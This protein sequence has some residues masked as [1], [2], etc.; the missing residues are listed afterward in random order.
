MSLRRKL[1]FAIPLALLVAVG[2][3]K[4]D[5]INYFPPHPAQV[6]VINLMIEPASLD[7]QIGGS[8]AFSAVPFQAL[9]GYQS[10][11]NKTTSF[12]IAVTGSTTPLLSFNYPLAG[13][14]PYTLVLMGS[15]SNPSATLLAEVANAPTNGNIQLSVFNAAINNPS[16]DI[17]VTAP[18]ADITQL[19]PSYFNVSYN[20]VSLNLAY[21]PG[22]YQIQICPQGTKT[23]IYDSGGTVLQPNIALTLLAYTRGSAALVNAAVIESKG[24]GTTLDTIFALV[25]AINAGTPSASVDL[26][27]GTTE[28]I[29]GVAYAN[30]SVYQQVPQGATTLN[31]EAS[32]T[33][34][35]TIASMPAVLPPAT[36]VST[37]VAGPAGA[38][39][40]YVLTDL[41]LPP[42]GSNVR[43]RFVNT[44]WNSNPVNVAV[45][46]V[47]QASN[48]AFPN[49]SGYVQIASGTFPI[50]F[51][52]AVTGAVVLQ[53]ENVNLTAAGTYTVYAIGPA[54]ALGGFV[55]QDD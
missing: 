29:A 33:P 52:D 48:V 41:N 35:T 39:Q 11:E 12:S 43:M 22:T 42:V 3:C 19:F 46:N 55:T 4:I 45:N 18:G 25:K 7:V 5:T 26:L 1:L 34:G 38:L 14:Q 15:L 32:D 44:S 49:A 8:P 9:T 24:G 28:E 13:E 51:T 37:F 27:L 10:Y 47:P 53:L 6:R 16:V 23:V 30:A 50:T 2:G 20:G 36:D 31:F 40:A 54:G 17:Y 21:P